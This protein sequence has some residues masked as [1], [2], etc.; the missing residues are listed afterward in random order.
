MPSQYVTTL[1]E[2]KSGGTSI[3]YQRVRT[4]GRA[5]S[6]GFC[7]IGDGE[8]NSWKG[9][10]W[11]CLS[12]LKCLERKYRWKGF[13]PRL[14]QCRLTAKLFFIDRNRWAALLVYQQICGSRI[15][16]ILE[17]SLLFPHLWNTNQIQ[18]WLNQ[19]LSAFIWL[20]PGVSLQDKKPALKVYFPWPPQCWALLNRM[21]D[22]CLT[23]LSSSWLMLKQLDSLA[24]SP[25]S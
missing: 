5:E 14:T 6:L 9:L 8:Y 13:L 20:F 19:C 3:L 15:F 24:E 17:S 16:G 25:R 10:D 23:W 18:S 22:S 7:I 21:P 4:K 1:F 11:V 12:V 2:I